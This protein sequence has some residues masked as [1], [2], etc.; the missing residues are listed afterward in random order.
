MTVR[1]ISFHDERTDPEGPTPLYSQ[2][3]G[4][5]QRNYGNQINKDGKGSCFRGENGETAV[6]TDNSSRS[7]VHE[8]V[9]INVPSNIASG[10]EAIVNSAN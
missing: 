10:V 5:L 4:Y 7:N 6:L 2:V 3:W 9:L 8:V 1:V